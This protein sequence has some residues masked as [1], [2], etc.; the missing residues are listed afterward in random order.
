MKMLE[1]MNKS[2]EDAATD[3]FLLLNKEYPEAPTLKL[4]GDR[5]RLTGLQRIVL[6]RGITSEEKAASRKAKISADPCGKKLHVDGYNVLF[7]IMNYLLGKTIF[8]ANDGMLRD[9]GGVYG[10]IED[11]TFFYKAADVLFDFVKKSGVQSVAIYLDSPVSNSAFHAKEFAKRM[12]KARID[13]KIVLAKPA[14]AELKKVSDGI[15]ATSDSGV[16][17][18]TGCEIFDLA[19]NA[20]AAN[21]Q[22]NAHELMDSAKHAKRKNG[23]TDYT[24]LAA[25]ATKARSLPTVSQVMEYK[26][27]NMN[28]AD[29]RDIFPV[30]R[31]YLYFNF[32]ADGPLPT[33]SKAAIIDALEECSEKGLM[34]VPKQIAVYENLRNELSILF[35]SKRENF[36]FTKN[37]SEGVLLALLAIDIKDDENFV[38]AQDAFP[39]TI[40]MMGNNC[41]GQ[42]RMVKMNDPEPLQDQ[43]LKVIDKKTRAIVLDWVHF[44]TGKVI[45]LAAI[46]QLARERNI[47]T[48]IDGIQGAGALKLELDASGI[49]FFVTGCHK[50]LLSPQGSGFIYVADHVWKHIER[51]SFGWLG[52]DWGD[53]SDFDIEPGLREGAAVMEYG[54]RSY[55]AAVGLVESLRLF[56]ALGIDAI[57]RHNLGLRKFFVEKI[58]DKGYQTIHSEKSA[59]IVPFRS[60]DMDTDLLKKRLEDSKVVVSLRN[61]YIR[62]GFHLV[63]DREEVE[64][65]IDLL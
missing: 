35:K 45:P 10:D 3:Y 4:V 58:I 42:M 59:P 18:A 40:K 33:T 49:D 48:I 26:E 39:T 21:Y 15:I 53:F 64:R 5:Y 52:Y 31:N 16:I 54:T 37:T 19:R 32:A 13:G 34:V 27:K 61:G 29:V 38:A 25:P 46:I 11:E 8:I 47:F 56:N 30:K 44:F 62:A 9:S 20:L 28:I 22:I 43:L 57:E 23:S 36:A 55:S 1:W 12:T 41:K 17:D 65:F 6:F 14:D 2:F 24:E 7:S 63:T 60:T 50:W 51:R